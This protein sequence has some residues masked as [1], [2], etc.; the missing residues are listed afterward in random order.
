[1]R[2]KWLQ[3]PAMTKPS[4]TSN[5]CF[6]KSHE[7]IA[8]TSVGA[9]LTQYLQPGAEVMTWFKWT[10]AEALFYARAFRSCLFTAATGRSI[11]PFRR[12][13]VWRRFM[14]YC[15]LNPDIPIPQ[16]TISLTL[17]RTHTC[18]SCG[19]SFSF[20][21]YVTAITDPWVYEVMW[22]ESSLS[23]FVL[24]CT[25]GTLRKTRSEFPRKD[26]S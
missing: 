19:L 20:A 8:L 14:K 24:G 25:S 26:K 12:G 11:P 2:K 3:I 6:L 1:M 5:S 7:F 16:A 21:A 4:A 9:S 18:D 17:Q 15:H 23:I 22:A 10:F 13:G